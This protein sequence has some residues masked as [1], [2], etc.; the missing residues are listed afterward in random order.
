MQQKQWIWTFKALHLVSNTIGKCKRQ[1]LCLQIHN[2]GWNCYKI[3]GVVS[4]A[5]N[6][7]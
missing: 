1:K 7:M 2:D 4:D 3:R 6:R 5:A